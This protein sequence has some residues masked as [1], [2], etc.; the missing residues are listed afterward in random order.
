MALDQN[1]K[2]RRISFGLL[3]AI[4]LIG[5]VECLV[6]M[7]DPVGF[8]A[9][10]GIPSLVSLKLKDIK[11]VIILWTL[12]TMMSI[13]LVR[14][15]IYVHNADEDHYCWDEPIQSSGALWVVLTVIP[16]LVMA[17]YLDVYYFFGK[18]AQVLALAAFAAKL[19]CTGYVAYVLIRDRKMGK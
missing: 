19:I 17:V 13:V 2:T 14:K 15:K 12:F 4:F 10:S 1:A 7:L 9:A 5:I 3:H 18:T 16:Q 11:L 6:L 8:G